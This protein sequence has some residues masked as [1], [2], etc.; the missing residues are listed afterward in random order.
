[1]VYFWVQI[2]AICMIKVMPKAATIVYIYSLYEFLH[3][4]IVGCV[5]T[6][7]IYVKEVQ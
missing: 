1:M 5:C 3:G 6:Y 4:S 2:N 7:S